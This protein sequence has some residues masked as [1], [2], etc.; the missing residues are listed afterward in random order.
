MDKK[1]FLR[2]T[3]QLTMETDDSG[4]TMVISMR[5][6]YLQDVF[7]FV[8]S[9]LFVLPFF[10][11][12]RSLNDPSAY[13]VIGF[14]FLVLMAALLHSVNGK[15]SVNCTIRRNF[16]VIQ[17]ERGGLLGTSLLHRN[18]D[19]VISDVAGFEI[20]DRSRGDFY[21]FQLL[22]V[23]K[24]GERLDL[25]GN[26]LGVIEYRQ[27]AEKIRNFINPQLPIKEYR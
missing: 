7:A 19:F 11:A 22:V 18:L 26:N 4:S 13:C 24:S 17:Y 6:S 9:V 25:F 3:R 8:L 20:K 10:L 21:M 23:F 27:V 1:S 2:E 16:G 15:R 14:I 12:P 5:S